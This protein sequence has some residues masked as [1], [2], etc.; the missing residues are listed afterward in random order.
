MEKLV[1]FDKFLAK[2]E[3]SDCPSDN[4]SDDE[5][6]EEMCAERYELNTFFILIWNS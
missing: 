3:N 5:N 4:S 1:K 6:E 2:Q